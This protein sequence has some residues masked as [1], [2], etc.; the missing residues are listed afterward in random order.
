M[1]LQL[2]IALPLLTDPEIARRQVDN[3]ASLY[4]F[5]D[6]MIT[7]HSDGGI[8]CVQPLA[9]QRVE[10]AIRCTLTPTLLILSVF[11]PSNIRED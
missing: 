10:F 2:E 11:R 6:E 5:R 9:E 1:A 7:L 8:L 3:P 4:R